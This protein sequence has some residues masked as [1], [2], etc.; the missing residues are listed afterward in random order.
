MP[1]SQEKFY[2]KHPSKMPR[3]QAPPKI[4]ENH[5]SKMHRLQASSMRGH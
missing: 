3:L 5:P 1:K 4:Y 2:E